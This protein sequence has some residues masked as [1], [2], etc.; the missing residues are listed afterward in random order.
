M[1]W[2]WLVACFALLGCNTDE[3]ALGCARTVWVGESC[4]EL[5][6]AESKARA[7]LEIQSRASFSGREIKDFV[8][9]ECDGGKTIS[10]VRCLSNGHPQ[11][12]ILK[13][14]KVTGQLVLI[15]PE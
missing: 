4:L 6:T 3:D 5:T 9:Y 12:F 13:P 15:R 8:F 2:L 11:E 1:R 14:D 7:S 10:A